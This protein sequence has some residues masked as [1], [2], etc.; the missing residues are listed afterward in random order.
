LK[1]TT[2]CVA[3]SKTEVICNLQN[4]Q[5][6]VPHLPDFKEIAVISS[7][8]L[9]SYLITYYES[10]N[11]KKNQWNEVIDDLILANNTG[12]NNEEANSAK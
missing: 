10:F 5:L 7:K 3:N 9:K 8:N 6:T 11:C 12:S 2:G 4:G 1:K